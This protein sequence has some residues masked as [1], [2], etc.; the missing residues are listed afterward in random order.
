M[1]KILF[2]FDTDD[3]LHVHRRGCAD[4]RKSHLRDAAEYWHGEAENCREAIEQAFFDEGG[5]DYTF[6]DARG[7]TTFHECAALEWPRGRRPKRNYVERR[8]N[9]PFDPDG[10]DDETVLECLFGRK[11]TWRN[12]Y[13]NGEESASVP[14]EGAR[15]KNGRLSNIQ[16]HL[17]ETIDGRR[18]LTFVDAG[19]TG[20][21]S[22]ALETIMVVK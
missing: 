20:F 22:V 13:T 15:A 3:Y 12:S 1:P 17:T 21:R 7:W 8:V 11:I 2:L 4:I 19:G 9:L 16:T 14:K 18:I 6:D 10:D 5:E